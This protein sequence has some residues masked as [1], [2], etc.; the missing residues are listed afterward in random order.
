MGSLRPSRHGPNGGHHP[1]HP[2]AALGAG[3]GVHARR[4]AGDN[5]PEPPAARRPM[6]TRGDVAHLRRASG[7]L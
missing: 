1:K 2:K 5:A 6:G 4:I 7:V 3:G